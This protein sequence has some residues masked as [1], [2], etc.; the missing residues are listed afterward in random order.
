MRLSS[1]DGLGALPQSLRVI[2]RAGS[3][4]REKG[5]MLVYWLKVKGGACSERRRASGTYLSVDAGSQ[6]WRARTQWPGAAGFNSANALARRS[7]AIATSSPQRISGA[8]MT[9][10]YR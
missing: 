10:L 4:E 3:R 2:A 8:A 9:Q 5:S 6:A 7:R 1:V